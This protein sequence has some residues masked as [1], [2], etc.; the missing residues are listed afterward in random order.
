MIEILRLDDNLREIGIRGD[1]VY[2]I[3]TTPTINDVYDL[4]DKSFYVNTYMGMLNKLLSQ[5]NLPTISIGIGV[6]IDEELVV[7]AGRKGV[8]INNAVWIG[9]A[10]TKASNLSSLGNKN[11][12][13]PICFSELAYNNFIGKLVENNGEIARGWFTRRYN[14][15]YSVYYDANIID[16]TFNNWI[17]EGMKD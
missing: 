9:N 15:D 6:S 2:G 13:L 11:Y 1:C 14:S 7:K 5:N 4:A 17:M 12:I 8:G 16:L 10:V 3:Y